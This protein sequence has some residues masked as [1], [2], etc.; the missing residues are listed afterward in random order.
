MCVVMQACRHE[1][2][3]RCN[4][5]SND[6]SGPNSTH[7]VRR[8]SDGSGMRSWGSGEVSNGG[9]L[10]GVGSGGLGCGEPPFNA[11]QVRGPD[12]THTCTQTRAHTNHTY[13]YCCAALPRRALDLAL[14]IAY[15]H[16]HVLVTSPVTHFQYAY[17]ACMLCSERAGG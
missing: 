8:S 6:S 7:P 2:L 12:T 16:S 3:L 1:V 11:Q 9:E 10:R 13:R 4:T 5:A 17:A 15:C 14:E